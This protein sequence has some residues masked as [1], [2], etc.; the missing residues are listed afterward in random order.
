VRQLAMGPKPKQLVRVWCPG[1]RFHNHIG[2]IAEVANHATVALVTL[3]H[4]GASWF[5][6]DSLRDEWAIRLEDVAE[7]ARAVVNG[8]CSAHDVLARR[9]HGLLWV[10]E[11]YA[12]MKGL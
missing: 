7:A 9:L 6:I 2:R 1:H 12:A 8:D 5:T 4:A 11:Q 10:E 3:E